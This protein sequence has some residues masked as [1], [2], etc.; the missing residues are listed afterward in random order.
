M[1]HIAPCLEASKDVYLPIEQFI[2]SCS[3]IRQKN[4]I[5]YLVFLNHK[6]WLTITAMRIR[7]TYVWRS[8]SRSH[9]LIHMT[10]AF[11]SKWY[12]TMGTQ[13]VIH[14][15]N[16]TSVPRTVR[17]HCQW[18]GR[19]ESESIWRIPDSDQ[20]ESLLIRR[21]PGGIIPRIHA[22]VLQF[23]PPQNLESRS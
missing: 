8:R 11:V 21:D 1:H 10:T 6:Q 22:R 9:H 16:V 4:L 2:K 13:P 18:F 12:G 7:C 20:G 3:E 15:L 5:H 23:S 14:R 17:G 19:A